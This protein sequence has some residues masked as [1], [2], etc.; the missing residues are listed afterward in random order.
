MTK[1]NYKAQKVILQFGLTFG[2]IFPLLAF[3]AFVLTITDDK[4]RVKNHCFYM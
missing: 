3:Y 4:W 1:F 2:V